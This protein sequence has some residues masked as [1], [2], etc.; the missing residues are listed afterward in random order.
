MEF[1][2]F[3]KRVY[4]I[5]EKNYKR[6]LEKLLESKNSME[7]MY[8]ILSESDYDIKSFVAG[9][10]AGRYASISRYFKMTSMGL[11]VNFDAAMED[12]MDLLSLIN[13]LGNN[14]KYEVSDVV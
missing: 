4:D 6:I 2:E 12:T 9:F 14:N 13:S 8:K 1:E 5:E 3:K 11:A 10:L 7:L